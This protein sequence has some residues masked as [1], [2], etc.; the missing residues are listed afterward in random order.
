[1]VRVAS[2]LIV[3]IQLAKWRTFCS[4][5]SAPPVYYPKPAIGRLVENPIAVQEN[6]TWA[7]YTLPRIVI[8][9]AFCDCQARS[10]AAA[11]GQATRGFRYVHRTITTSLAA[12]KG[13]ATSTDRRVN[14]LIAASL[15]GTHPTY[16]RFRSNAPDTAEVSICRTRS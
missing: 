1:M 9:V 10:L 12:A 11:S 14:R 2:V 3:Q 13:Q 7:A 4:P 15:A 5:W 16:F 8:V 6:G